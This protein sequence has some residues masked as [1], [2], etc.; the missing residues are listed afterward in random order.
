MFLTADEQNGQRPSL[1]TAP[2]LLILHPVASPTELPV[3]LVE[4]RR[5]R[6]GR[7]ELVPVKLGGTRDGFG[8]RRCVRRQRKS[9][10]ERYG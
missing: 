10:Q 2:V 1:D 3:V 6:V 7:A 5:D 8:L 4:I 9:Q